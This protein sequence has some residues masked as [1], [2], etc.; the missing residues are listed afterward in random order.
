[1]QSN[2]SFAESGVLKSMFLYSRGGHACDWLKGL[3]W[4]KAMLTLLQSA[5]LRFLYS[6]FPYT[7]QCA[8]LVRNITCEIIYSYIP[9][10]SSKSSVLR[11][12]LNF[13]RVT[14]WRINNNK[15]FQSFGP[16]LL[17]ALS[18]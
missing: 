17:K 3:L 9:Y 7:V 11:A 13:G 2:E 1:M 8:V 14:E 6:A 5:D 4:E 10:A 16:A 15:L 18:P 12:D